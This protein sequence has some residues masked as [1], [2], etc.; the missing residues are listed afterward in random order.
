MT[1]TSSSKFLSNRIQRMGNNPSRGVMLIGPPKKHPLLQL[2]CLRDQVKHES[3]EGTLQASWLQTAVL[4]ALLSTCCMQDASATE[5]IPTTGLDHIWSEGS[6]EHSVTKAH[7]ASRIAEIADANFLGLGGSSEDNN[8]FTI[9]GT[10]FKKYLIEV[11]EGEKII[12]R[13]RG[14]TVDTCVSTLSAAAE[15]GLGPQFQGLPTGEKVR[16]AGV[17]SCRRSEGTEL[18]T[19]CARSC[20]TACSA[21]MQN[22]VTKSA[23]ETGILVEE[24]EK[25]RMT[26][27]CTRDCR[28]EC[29]KPG[30]AFDFVSTSRR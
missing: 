18:P 27:S 16:I 9:Y 21:A 11:L 24:K 4:T 2:P 6:H 23:S 15:D 25:I 26:K 22:Y 5:Q 8:P 3:Q 28:S 14:F 7:T 30:K 20:E 1:S 17:S 13:K 10:V 12:S 29:T 19:A